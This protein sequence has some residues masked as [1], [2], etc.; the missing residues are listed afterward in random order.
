MKKLVSLLL[1]ITF[2]AIPETSYGVFGLSKCEK[3][4]KAIRAEETVG[5]ELWKN[6]SKSKRALSNPQLSRTISVLEELSLVY[7]SDD[8]VFKIV[9]RNI[10]CFTPKQVAYARGEVATHKEFYKILAGWKNAIAKGNRSALE[11][12]PQDL[13][14]WVKSAY[15]SYV[16][17]L[18]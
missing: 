11:S 12:T 14:T 9:E 18:K 6:F 5:L 8:V 10:K 13:L 1:V 16:S 7:K 15:P 3:A 17:F 4:N 2:V